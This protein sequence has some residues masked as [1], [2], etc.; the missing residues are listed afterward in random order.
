MGG[1]VCCARVCFRTDVLGRL[2]AS[3]PPPAHFNR[4][5]DFD[6]R[7]MPISLMRPKE[8]VLTSDV[9]APDPE[10]AQKCPGGVGLR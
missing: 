8:A 3:P 9:G 4:V 2:A 5:W 1:C 6:M 10:S 7:P